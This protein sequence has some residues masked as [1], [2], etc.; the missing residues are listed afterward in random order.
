MN[1]GSLRK[2][3]DRLE[4]IVKAKLDAIA[5]SVPQ[6]SPELAADADDVTCFAN[7]FLEAVA[8]PEGLSEEES[9]KRFVEAMQMVDERIRKGEC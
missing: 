6:G 1:T 8:N 9:V 4:K 3:L 2:R 5:S 7:M